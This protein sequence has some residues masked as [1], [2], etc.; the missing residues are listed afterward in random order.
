[1]DG[2][3]CSYL[4]QLSQKPTWMSPSSNNAKKLKELVKELSRE[5]IHKEI[6]LPVMDEQEG[7]AESSAG[8]DRVI[9]NE[10]AI[11]CTPPSLESFSNDPHRTTSNE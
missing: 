1:M 5:A 3:L 11:A 6:I 10:D 2:V 4:E 8:I 9:P 7:V